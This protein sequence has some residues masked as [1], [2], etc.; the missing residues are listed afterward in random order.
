MMALSLRQPWAWMVVHGRKRIENRRWSTRFRGLFLI[1]AARGMTR[2]EYDD[3]VAFASY[4]APDLVVPETASLERGGLVGRARL[5]DV[6]APCGTPCA[7]PWHMP[8]Q[9][10]FVLADVEPLAFRP[11]RGMLG[12]FEAS[13][14]APEP[15]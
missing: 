8:A 15:T 14:L 6:V 4:V 3:A 9:F 5:V 12:F 1:H 11:L 2:A 10:G 13:D 7:H